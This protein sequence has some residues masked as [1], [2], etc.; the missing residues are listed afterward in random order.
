MRLTK[1]IHRIM[2]N[3]ANVDFHDLIRVVEAF[4]YQLERIS[5]SHRIYRHPITR[6]KLNLQPVGKQ[7]KPYQVRQFI[8]EVE[9]YNLSIEDEQP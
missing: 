9:S 3:P 2:A 8:K 7:A 6:Q 5:G 4:G 1:L